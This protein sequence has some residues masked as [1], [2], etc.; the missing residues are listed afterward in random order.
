M[1]KEIAKFNKASLALRRAAAKLDVV[2]QR[3]M[4]KRRAIPRLMELID[5]LPSDYK[6]KRKI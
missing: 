6:G 5:V 3:E 2:V 1:T 4:R